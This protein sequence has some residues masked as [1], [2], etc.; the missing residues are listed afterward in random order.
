MLKKQKPLW[1]KEN[2]LV[3]SNHSFSHRVFK[4]IVPRTRKNASFFGKELK[5]KMKKKKRQIADKS[6]VI[7]NHREE[8]NANHIWKTYK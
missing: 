4:R 2:L 3:T 6:N 1:E 7:I 8:T 5:H